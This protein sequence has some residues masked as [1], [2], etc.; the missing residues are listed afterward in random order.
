[1]GNTCSSSNYN[2]ESSQLKLFEGHDTPTQSSTPFSG[3]PSYMEFIVRGK[4]M[5][6]MYYRQAEGSEWVSVQSSRCTLTVVTFVPFIH[7]SG[8]M[9]S[10]YSEN[11]MFQT[12]TLRRGF[13]P[14]LLIDLPPG[15]DLNT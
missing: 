7:C 3:L 12:L 4:R 11:D 5:S 8:S 15:V 6:G 1:M 10:G 2:G 9:E 13:K 14:E